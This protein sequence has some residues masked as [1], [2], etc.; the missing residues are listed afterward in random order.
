MTAALCDLIGNTSSNYSLT[1]LDLTCQFAIVIAH[2]TLANVIHQTPL[3][4]S[5]RRALVVDKFIAYHNLVAKIS[6]LQLSNGR[7]TFTCDLHRHDHFTVRSMYQFQI[8]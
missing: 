8:N 2:V 1:C 4:A 5:F 3:N 7:D 6:G